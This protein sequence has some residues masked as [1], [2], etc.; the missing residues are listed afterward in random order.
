MASGKSEQIFIKPKPN[1]LQTEHYLL[2]NADID[3]EMYSSI[4]YTND[5]MTFQDHKILDENSRYEYFI[6]C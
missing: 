4:Y 1:N 5:Q 6:E 2:H 3:A